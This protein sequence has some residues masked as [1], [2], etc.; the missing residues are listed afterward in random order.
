MTRL[1]RTFGRPPSPAPPWIP[2]Q[3]RDDTRKMSAG[4][5]F[6]GGKDL[7]ATPPRPWM[8]DQV[9]HDTEKGESL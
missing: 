6:P 7:M 5:S 2:H 9:R 1:R 8:P 4:R 3:V